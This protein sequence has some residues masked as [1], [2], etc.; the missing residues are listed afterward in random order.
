M[1]EVYG[2]ADPVYL[3]GRALF[4]SFVDEGAQDAERG[5]RVRLRD[6][7]REALDG[8]TLT[9]L[10]LSWLLDRPR[11]FQAG[12]DMTDPRVKRM[13]D[14]LVTTQRGD[15]GWRP[16]WSEESSPIY[17]ALAVKVLIL[18]GALAKKDVQAAV[19]AYAA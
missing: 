15:G 11:R 4:E 13:M 6:G 12:Y 18:S 19:K 3:K 9:H 5:Y 7:K 8:Y 14:A 16:F 10:L 17:T 1:R 2:E